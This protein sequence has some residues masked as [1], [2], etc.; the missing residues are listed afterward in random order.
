MMAW[1]KDELCDVSGQQDHVAD[2]SDAE[3]IEA[4][5]SEPDAF[6]ILFHRHADTVL[7][8]LVRRVGRD[9]AEELLGD[10][11]RVAFEGRVRFDLTRANARP[12]LYGI[13]TNLLRHHRRAEGRR[14]RAT[15]KAAAHSEVSIEPDPV[16]RRAEVRSDLVRTAELL[17]DLPDGER[18]VLLL[19]VFEELSYEEMASALE[20]PIGTVRSRLNR[21]RS[22][23]R[24]LLGVS[25]QH[26]ENDGNSADMGSTR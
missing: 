18:D 22:R 23:L 16:G 10:L 6:G 19:S 21:A 14:L 15:A 4:S 17:D 9:D 5:L 8:F 7:R 25:G 3:I 24:E 11:F 13:G 20:L 26:G 1:L 2:L 12:W